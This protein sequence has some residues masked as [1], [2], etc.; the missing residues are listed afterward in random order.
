MMQDRIDGANQLHHWKSPQG[1]NCQI[2]CDP[3]YLNISKICFRNP[4]SVPTVTS[5]PELGKKKFLYLFV[6]E[7]VFF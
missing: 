3:F 4:S 6:F 2:F 7:V 1:K 5:V